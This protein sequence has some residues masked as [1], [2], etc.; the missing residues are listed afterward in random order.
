[1]KRYRIHFYPLVV[2][3]LLLSLGARAQTKV[4]TKTYVYSLLDTVMAVDLNFDSLLRDSIFTAKLDPATLWDSLRCDSRATY[5][6]AIDMFSDSVRR[7]PKTGVIVIPPRENGNA[8]GVTVITRTA[9]GYKVQGSQGSVKVYDTA[10]V[11]RKAGE[12]DPEVVVLEPASSIDGR[13]NRNVCWERFEQWFYIKRFRGHWA[14]VEWGFNWFL[15]DKG[16]LQLR[17]EY[18]PYRLKM[19]RSFNVNL[20][21][22]QYSVPFGSNQFGMLTGV[23]IS[24]HDLH[25]SG[26]ATLKTAER[27]VV[28]DSTFCVDGN[29]VTRSSLAMSYLTVPLLFE[30]QTH[31]RHYTRAFVAAGVIGGVRLWSHAR[32]TYN[33]GQKYKRKDD[34][35]LSDVR[36][37]V[38]LRAGIGYVRGYVNFYPQGLFE[39]GRG[40]KIYPLEV[41]LILLSF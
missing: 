22:L 36:Y 27:G 16:S 1:M 35:Y 18:E 9:D 41:G 6:M 20:N 24:F 34:F 32:V 4:Q 13:G 40:P 38:T 3:L 33:G 28:M 37:A 14:G 26:S 25:F 31:G 7:D 12:R 19:F 5:Q 39:R 2:A 30:Y 15:D 8:S 11:V 29:W 17:D 23:G 21:F 10:I